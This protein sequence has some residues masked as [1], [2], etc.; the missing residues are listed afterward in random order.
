MRKKRFNE[1]QL[2][3]TNLCKFFFGPGCKRGTNCAFAHTA[4]G[5]LPKPDLYKTKLCMEW[6]S[7]NCK[8]GDSCRYAHGSEELRPCSEHSSSGSP[9][10]QDES[11]SLIRIQQRSGPRCLEDAMQIGTAQANPEMYPHDQKPLSS[12]STA[13]FSSWSTT[14]SSWDRPSFNSEDENVSVDENAQIKSKAS[15]PL[16]V[17]IGVDLDMIPD[18]DLKMDLDLDLDLDEDREEHAISQDQV[19]LPTYHQNLQA[20]FQYMLY[21]QACRT[22]KPLAP[23]MPNHRQGAIPPVPRTTAMPNPVEI[24]TKSSIPDVAF[25]I[26]PPA[27]VHHETPPHNPHTSGGQLA[28]EHVPRMSQTSYMGGED[29]PTLL[30]MISSFNGQSSAELQEAAMQLLQAEPSHYED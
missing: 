4:E 18:M 13:A 23:G 6:R 17:G 19:K 9:A 2:K 11:V 5:L 14:A 21:L 3:C 29:Q 15:L 20:K 25:T 16:H 7:G 12:F 1:S 26:A 28:K 27:D 10:S 22:T 24:V 30:K 8:L